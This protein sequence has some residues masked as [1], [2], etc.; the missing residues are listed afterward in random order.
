M[1]ARAYHEISPSGL[2]VA[3]AAAAAHPDTTWSLV[4]TLP[5]RDFDFFDVQHL[6]PSRNIELS[7]G[8]AGNSAISAKSKILQLHDTVVL[9]H[10]GLIQHVSCVKDIIEITFI[11][12]TARDTFEQRTSPGTLLITNHRSCNPEN[13]RGVY[14]LSGAWDG[15]SSVQIAATVEQ[16]SLGDTADTLEVTYYKTRSREDYSAGSPSADLRRTKRQYSSCRV[17]KVA[18]PQNSLACG[19]TGLLLR[20]KLLR[21]FGAAGSDTTCARNCLNDRL[22]K[23]FMYSRRHNTC[24]TLKEAVGKQAFKRQQT[25]M[26]LHDKQ[27]WQATGACGV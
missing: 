19:V 13:E 20:P 4:P 11:S 2:S 23:S 7:F 6:Y 27:C 25:G 8:A 14:I 17:T 12:S 22:C 1:R 16:T 5:D 15:Q 21:I 3:V 18:R 26:L 9:E 24:I 10:S